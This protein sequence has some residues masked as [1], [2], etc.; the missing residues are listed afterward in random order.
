MADK[1]Q[2]LLESVGKLIKLRVP[3]DEIVSNLREVGIDEKQARELIRLARE[4]PKLEKSK[5]PEE[6]K[7]PPRVEEA[8][9]SGAAQSV[10]GRA[11]ETEKGKAVEEKKF[12]GAPQAAPATE[13]KPKPVV[14]PAAEKKEPVATALP[15]K[16]PSID[17]S[18]LWEKGIL[19]AVDQKLNEM[20]A[21]KS[22]L[23]GVIA[24]KADEIA[25]KEVDKMRVLFESQQ[26]LF[27][28]KVN[29]QLEK[30]AREVEQV[31]DQKIAEM[32][33]A[34]KELQREISA[35][36]KARAEHKGVLEEAKAK[37]AAL[38]GT[39]NRLVSEMN[40]EL[41]KAKSSMQEFMD[42]SQEKVREMDDRV[43][44]TL[45]VGMSVIE[46]LKAD[47]EAKLQQM[48][49]EKGKGIESEV[50]A[51]LDA[52]DDTRMAFESQ[53]KEHL[54]KIASMEKSLSSGL[55][56]EVHNSVKAEVALEIRKLQEARR[57]FEKQL[58][59]R[60][61]QL[62]ALRA[63]IQKEFSPEMF[64]Q[65]MEDLEVFK[66]QFI[67]VI[68]TN[69]GKFN[70]AIQRI[71]AQ[72]RA[73]EDQINKR[74]RLIDSKIK[75]LEDFEKAFAEEMGIAVEKAF[76]KKKRKKRKKKP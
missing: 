58:G 64:R 27:L 70:Q 6:E 42:S 57:A 46:G 1:K 40:S 21:I 74:I 13:V 26:S 68:E 60:L 76:E 24:K 69:V 50:R 10:W 37:L 53:V 29:A 59:D 18:K 35:L 73:L 14:G 34:S 31:I 67:K 62:D 20:K 11:E 9:P 45:E 61:M 19:A 56:E 8:T 75:E 66:R 5:P 25:K 55:R 63:A 71:N 65:Q 2:V 52:L 38:D 28:E 39:K 3:D 23:D 16:K 49:A 51:R 44:K 54:Q 17:L 47:A 22:N 33:A 4:Q 36:E 30:K 12:A 72:A 41:I 15:Q 32:G 7:K 48:A 43:N